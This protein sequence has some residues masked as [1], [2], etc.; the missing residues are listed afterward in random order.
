MTPHYSRNSF[1]KRQGLI[2]LLSLECSGTI[3]DH[4]NLWTPAW[5]AER[6]SVSKEKKMKVSIFHMVKNCL[7]FP[8]SDYLFIFFFSS[9]EQKIFF[10][11]DFQNLFLQEFFKENQACYMNCR[12]FSLLISGLLTCFPHTEGFYFHMVDLSFSLM[13][14]GF[15]VIFKSRFSTSSSQRN[16]SMFS[17]ST[18]FY[19]LHYKL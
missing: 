15:S 12:S 2:L 9:I 10:L 5:V 13:I 4:C 8:V 16:L 11:H 19:F 3:T 6:D 7:Y 18:L 14:N 17:F 1:L